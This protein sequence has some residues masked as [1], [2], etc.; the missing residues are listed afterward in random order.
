MGTWS[1]QQRLKFLR[2]YTTGS[3][4]DRLRRVHLG[5][6]APPERLDPGR[7]YRFSTYATWLIRDAI[8]NA[9]AASAAR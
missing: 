9:L 8:S 5:G 6:V 7:G 4:P 2:D 3:G 1:L